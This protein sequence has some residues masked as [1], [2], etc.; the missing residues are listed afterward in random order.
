MGGA[1]FPYTLW[2][3]SPTQSFPPFSIEYRIDGQPSYIPAYVSLFLKHG[4]MHTP[5]SMTR[6]AISRSPTTVALKE[7][8]QART[9]SPIP[10]YSVSCCTPRTSA[11]GAFRRYSSAPRSRDGTTKRRADEGNASSAARLSALAGGIDIERMRLA[12]SIRSGNATTCIWYV[13]ICKAGIHLGIC[14]KLS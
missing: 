6:V 1:E 10:K 3:P 12:R 9:S 13:Y 7:P 5:S 14:N 2:L 8:M 11:S 4:S